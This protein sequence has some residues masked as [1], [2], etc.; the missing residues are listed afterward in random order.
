MKLILSR[1]GFDA[2]Y[3]GVPSPIFPD[4]SLCPLPI[5]SREVVRL[6]DVMWRGRPLS[7]IVSAITNQRISPCVGV[8]LDP[9]IQKNARSRRPGWRPIFGQVNAA[10]THL[11][12]QG[13]QRGDLFL[14]FGWFRRIVQV[15]GRWAYDR[16]APDL[17]VIFGWLQIED[18]VQPTVDAGSVPAWA[19]EHPHVRR[20]RSM[21][22]NNTVYCGARCLEVPTVSG[23]FSGAGV[24]DTLS[25][26]LTLTAEAQNR[27][28][29][30]L[31]PW[32]SPTPGKPPLSF[33]ADPRRWESE[34]SYCRL[35][36]VG[37]GQE[38][39]LDCDYYPEA[40]GW[41]EQLLSNAAG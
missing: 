38:F 34:K 15:N 25:P 39:V 4:D 7:D 8:H 28:V 10:Q 31:P 30:Q 27:S 33:H 20:A 19:S 2:T 26:S 5:P 37:R 32:F 36:T 9:D 21:A 17:H 35:K 13:V 40:F 23:R 12:N 41:L 24:F 16:T 1:K 11:L 18:M 29:W 3:G 22:T 6:K 14:F